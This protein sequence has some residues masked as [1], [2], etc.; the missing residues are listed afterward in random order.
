MPSACRALITGNRIE[1]GC[2]SL[3]RDYM[4]VADLGT[5]IICL[6]RS[7]LNGAVNLGTGEP[8]RLSLILERLGRISEKTRIARVERVSTRH[9]RP[10][11]PYR[12]QPAD[13][14]YRL[15]SRD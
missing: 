11:N 9:R 14:K 8:V 15:D 1:F 10:A 2:G 5:A 13:P 6:A 12:R 4:H 7:T 3:W